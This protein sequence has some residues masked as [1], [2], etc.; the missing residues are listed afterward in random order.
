MLQPFEFST[1]GETLERLRPLVKRAR[2]C[3]QITVT[4]DDWQRRPDAV[5]DELLQR[6]QPHLLAVRSSAANE[7]GHESSLA[8]VHHSQINVV[9]ERQPLTS[10]IETVAASYREPSPGDQVL[11]QPMVPDVTVSGVLLT[12]DLDS[13]SPYFVINYDD[14]SGRTDSVTGGV[15][16]KALFVRR[17]ATGAVRSDRF[18]RL[19]DCVMEIE[20][21]TGSEKLDV[22]FCIDGDDQIFILQVRPLAAQKNWQELDDGAFDGILG[23]IR[24]DVEDRMVPGEGLAGA[25]TIFGEMPDWNPAEMIGNVP[26]PLALSLYKRLITDDVWAQARADMGYRHVA[27]PLMVDFRGRP[28]IDVRL[29]F[30][31]FL[32]PDLDPAFANALVD[33][34][35]EMLRRRRDL[36][37]KIEF[38]IAVTC[39]DLAFAEARQSLVGAGFGKASLDQLES[40]L[41]E[42]TWRALQAGAPGLG[43]DLNKARQLLKDRGGETEVSLAAIGKALDACKQQGTLPFAKLARHGF[44]AV[45]FLQSLIKRGILEPSQMDLFMRG[46]RTVAVDLVDHM[47]DLAAGTMSQDDFLTRYGHLRP[48]TYDILSFRYDERPD[49]YLGHRDRGAA[50][51][52]EPLSLGEKQKREI[53]GA[54]EEAGYAVGADHLFAYVTEAIKAREESKFAFSRTISDVLDGLARWGEA[55]GFSREDLSFFTIDEILEVPPGRLTELLVDRKYDYRISRAIRLPHL[56]RDEAEIDVVR[57]PLGQPTFITGAVVMAPGLVLDAHEIL[58]INDKLVLIESADPGFDWI[59]S[60]DIKG[61]ITCFGGAN[62]HMAIRCAEFGLP[63]A[64]GCGEQLFDRLSRAAVIELNCGARTV[65][66]TDG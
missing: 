38:E 2:F 29:S 24:A 13:G 40:G 23:N 47:A 53:D 19:I 14:F 32:P 44:M 21:V 7:D 3:D 61:L 26:R 11:I 1:K 41:A 30:N 35:L 62:S 57:M 45:L 5:L 51:H 18:R 10:A 31:S 37:D 20:E 60:H 56:I 12:R 33:H 15:E 54:L 39:R 6:F 65:K 66:A 22:E 28:Y 64:I 59:F 9:P 34:Q 55:R 43:P 16:S 49:L 27:R 36:H 63:A 52:P 50:E 25:T 58:D 17:S 8:G 46:I 48:G 42:I 4:T